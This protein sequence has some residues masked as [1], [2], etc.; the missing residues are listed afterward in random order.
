[1]KTP[2]LRTLLASGVL[3]ALIG[4]TAMPD[5]VDLDRLTQSIVR[6]SFR[7]QGIVK[8]S[9]LFETDE[10]NRL[11]SQADAS[12]Q[13]L[14]EEQTRAIEE[15]NLKAVRWPSDGQFLGDWRQGETI[16]QSG[17]GL[18]W[19]DS[20]KTVNGGNCYNCHQIDPKEISY[21]TLGPSLVQYGK[22]RGM[23]EQAL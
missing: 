16:A 10:T 23:R 21:G 4:C 13:A 22:L 9:V 7:D 14:S 15:S 3:L 11:C 8:T 20:A 5:A 2:P 18:T 19:T 6:A 12:G 17:V 1:M